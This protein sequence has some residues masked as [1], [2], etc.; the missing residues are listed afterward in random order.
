MKD[1]FDALEK[2]HNE[3]L[4]SLT[5][6]TAWGPSERMTRLQAQATELSNMGELLGRG[7]TEH[8]TKMSAVHKDRWQ[9]SLSAYGK[10]AESMGEAQKNG[11]TH[12]RAPKLLERRRAADGADYGY[13]AR[14]RRYLHRARR[15]RMPAGSCL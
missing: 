14:A 11:R 9:K 2:G 15:S 8:M 1:I 4:E 3:F 6:A 5:D 13:A 12:R 10:I 7:L